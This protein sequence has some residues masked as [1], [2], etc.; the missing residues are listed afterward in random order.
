[1]RRIANADARV[2]RQPA[3]H[4][5]GDPLASPGASQTDPQQT[6]SMFA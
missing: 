2:S 4:G 1:M 6:V 5:G 3:R